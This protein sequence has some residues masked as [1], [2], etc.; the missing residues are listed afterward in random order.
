[1]RFCS[2]RDEQPCHADIDQQPQ[3]GRQRHRLALHGLGHLQALH[4]GNGKPRHQRQQAQAIDQCGDKLRAP[5]TVAMQVRGW[6]S[7]N[8]GRRRSDQQ[9]AR[10]VD[11]VAGV[12]HQ[13]QRTG[14]PAD[15]RLDSGECQGKAHGKPEQAARA[16]AMGVV[17]IMMVMVMRRCAHAAFPLLMHASSRP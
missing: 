16:I 14:P 8:P 11:H 10:I 2:P 6:P 1:M 13:R 3:R 5:Q 15:A 7:G 4:G 9:G 12:R 17:M